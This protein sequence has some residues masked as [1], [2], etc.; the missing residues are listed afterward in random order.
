[1]GRMASALVGKEAFLVNANERIAKHIIVARQTTGRATNMSERAISTIMDHRP[2][3][4]ATKASLGRAMYPPA[5]GE[6]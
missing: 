5:L 1:M 3:G 2:T 4:G 6:R